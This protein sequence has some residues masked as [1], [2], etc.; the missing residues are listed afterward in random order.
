M[1][2]TVEFRMNFEIEESASWREHV[3]YFHYVEYSD[4]FHSSFYRIIPEWLQ[5]EERQKSVQN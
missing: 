1:K 3:L 5:G 4:V 2:G